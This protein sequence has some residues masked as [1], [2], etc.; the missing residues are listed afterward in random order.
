MTHLRKLYEALKERVEILYDQQ[1]EEPL[2]ELRLDVEQLIQLI[3]QENGYQY[4]QDIDQEDIFQQLIA[5]ST[6]A[7]VE[8]LYK[9][10]DKNE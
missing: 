7:I 4:D 3:C 10:K 5:K 2:I 1:E 8:S 6:D 9:D